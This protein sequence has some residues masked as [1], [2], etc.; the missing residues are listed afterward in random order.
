MFF[1][2]IIMPL[3]SSSSRVSGKLFENLSC[4]IQRAP[5]TSGS[6][7]VSFFPVA[8][9]SK[10]K[11]LN[12]RDLSLCMLVYTR[13]ESNNSS[14][15]CILYRS[16]FSWKLL[17]VKRFVWWF[18]SVIIIPEA[19]Q[20][21]PGLKC[22]RLEGLKIWTGFQQ[23][24]RTKG[25]FLAL[26]SHLCSISSVMCFHCC[27]TADDS[28]ACCDMWCEVCCMVWCS[29][30][31]YDYVDLFHSSNDSDNE[32]FPFIFLCFAECCCI[33]LP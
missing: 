24:K 17:S 14:Q 26:F 23:W 32:E 16:D 27:T 9:A 15:I 33:V 10:W 13:G 3:C 4:W 18:P 22:M 1:F 8:K 21:Q 25:L 2:W 6:S 28:L 29:M 20:F 19:C 12:E 31:H 7:K 5:Q 11:I 30:M